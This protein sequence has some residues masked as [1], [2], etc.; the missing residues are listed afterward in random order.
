MTSTRPA[1]PGT[2]ALVGMGTHERYE[3]DLLLQDRGHEVQHPRLGERI[4]QG[5]PDPPPGLQ[6]RP[7]HLF[8]AITKRSRTEP[9]N[10]HETACTF[11]D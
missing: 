3:Y 7:G 1:P 10:V 6:G 4:P 2:T 5:G 9:E 8:A 11:S